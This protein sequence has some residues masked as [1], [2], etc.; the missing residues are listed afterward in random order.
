MRVRHICALTLALASSGMVTEQAGGRGGRALTPDDTVQDLLTHP[1]F[2]G[3][4][5]LLLPWDDRTYNTMRLRNL[6][7]LRFSHRRLRRSVSFT[8]V[9]LSTLVSPRVVEIFWRR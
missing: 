3:F 9:H 7:S 8:A 1:A 6:D 2:S 4:S 5:R